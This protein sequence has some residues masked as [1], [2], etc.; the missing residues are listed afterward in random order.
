MFYLD[1]NDICNEWWIPGMETASKEREEAHDRT[2]EIWELLLV[3]LLACW[4]TLI[5]Q[6]SL[7][8][9]SIFSYRKMR[10][11][12]LQIPPIRE[13]GSVLSI[14]VKCAPDSWLFGVP[15]I[16][17]SPSSFHLSYLSRN[18]YWVIEPLINA[19]FPSGINIS[20]LSRTTLSL[21]IFW[22]LQF[23]VCQ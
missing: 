3:L 2:R 7:L 12:G 11:W 17:S 14:P 8:Q 21:F 6:C 19:K 20:L 13:E 4:M 10:R 23:S 1:F 5:S 22:P 15:Y 16:L 9:C 18:G